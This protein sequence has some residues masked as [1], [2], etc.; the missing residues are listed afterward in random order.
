VPT[1]RYFCSMSPPGDFWGDLGYGYFLA[2]RQLALIRVVPLQTALR[3]PGYGVA[4]G[5]W[6][7]YPEA[8]T[9]SLTD[10]DTGKLVPFVNV[11]CGDDGPLGHLYTVGVTNV[12][13][14][15]V[16]SVRPTPYEVSSLV[17]YS[18]V[19]VPTAEDAAMLGRE[20]IPAACAPPEPDALSRLL[21]DIVREP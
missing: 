16:R 18:V 15:A 7:T 5:R 19:I 9:T 12:A 3:Q 11:V 10:P 20:G 1:I 8:F 2:L 14:T 4:A 13:I 17:H 21:V 6:A